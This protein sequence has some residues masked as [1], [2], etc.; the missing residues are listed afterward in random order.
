M[1]AVLVASTGSTVTFV[2]AVVVLCAAGILLVSTR[3]SHRRLRQRMLA[4]A[5]RLGVGPVDGASDVRVDEV[6]SLIE[7]AVRD[8]RFEDLAPLA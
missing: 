2:V 6:L 1:I 7:S 8:R 3:V 4:S 5:E